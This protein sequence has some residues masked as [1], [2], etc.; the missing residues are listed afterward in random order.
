[1]QTLPTTP[2]DNCSTLPRQGAEAR[3]GMVLGGVFVGTALRYW[4]M[5]FPRTCVELRRWRE[6]ATSISDPTLRR[7][8]LEAL[9]KRGNIEGAA[10][11]AV[12][13]PRA[14]RGAVVRALVALQSIYNYVDLLAE[15]PSEDPVGNSRRLHEALL[16][17]LDPEASQP[18]YY[19]HYPQHDDGGYLEDMAQSARAAL[20]TLPSYGRVAPA[21]RT[22]S[23][24]IVAY[25]SLSLGEPE[26]AQE[27]LQHWAQ[28]QALTAGRDLHWWEM[29]GA[30]GSSLGIYAL[31]AAAAEPA[32]DTEKVE[33]LETAYFPW[34][35]ALH[36][37]LD[38]LLDE[39]EDAEVGQLNLVNCYANSTEA[40]SRMGLIAARAMEHAY[41]L[42][43]GEKHAVGVAAM[44]GYYLSDLLASNTTTPEAMLAARNVAEEIGG[45]AKPILLMFRVRRLAG[46]A[47]LSIERE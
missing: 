6:R 12:F 25:Q 14:R 36:S 32:L 11:F 13:A 45:L 4:L 44:A 23:W 39:A 43:S 30:G 1:M 3:R 31:I 46:A 42:R 10:A 16:V 28:E 38:S 27:E 37:L 29:A 26:H 34:I 2:T 33:A 22:A 47:P 40:A 7:L 15:Q 19:E 24:R 9:Q 5:I 8:A 17:A 20:C 35:G 41:R 21:A 18:D